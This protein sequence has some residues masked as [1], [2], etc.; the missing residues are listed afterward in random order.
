[1]DA[2]AINAYLQTIDDF[3]TVV[4]ENPILW[5]RDVLAFLGVTNQRDQ[6]QFLAEAQRIQ[7]RVQRTGERR[8]NGYV[9]PELPPGSLDEED[10][11]THSLLGSQPSPGI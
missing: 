4:S 9:P 8:G 3:L 5:S 1:M 11:R 6:R 2:D 7:N 10:F